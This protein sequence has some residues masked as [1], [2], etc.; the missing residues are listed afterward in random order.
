MAE[1][2]TRLSKRRAVFVTMPPL[3][4][5]IVRELLSEKAGLHVIDQIGDREMLTERLPR[6]QPDLVV[7][8]LGNGEGDDIGRLVLQVVPNGKV[9]A[10]SNNGRDACLL[11]M[12]LHRSR[13]LD[14]SPETLLS[15]IIAADFPARE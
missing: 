1:G 9:L 10:I 3:L 6:L 4:S 15:A 7:I 12:R 11:E 2:G 14:F 5:D 13:L 8:G